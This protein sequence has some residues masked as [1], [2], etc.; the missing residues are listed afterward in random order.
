MSRN[1]ATADL[2]FYVTATGN[3][4]MGDGSLAHPFATAARAY[5]VV[6]RGWD[7][8]GQYNVNVHLSGA[9]ANVRW[10]FLGPLV[11]AIGP[12]SFNIIGV[13]GSPGSTFCQGATGVQ[14]AIVIGSGARICCHDFS[15]NPG[16]GAGLFTVGG[17]ELLVH[18]LWF[19]TNGGAWI[20][21]AAGASSSIT[22]QG[23]HQLWS[24]GGPVNIVAVS[25][26]NAQI[27]LSGAWTMEYSPSWN[28]A[29]VQAD[30][31]GIVDGTGFSAT[32]AGN[33]PR[34]V[35]SVG[36][37]VFTGTGT[38]PPNFFPGSS[39]GSSAGAYYV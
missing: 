26:D 19:A 6:Q 31:G 34:Y 14:E 37:K 18:D 11:G 22:S 29:F 38:A 24:S 9:L 2:D 32:G 10:Q 4:A 12:Q 13:P 25:E 3:D 5:Q 23:G 27:N 20:F 17:G 30:L 16:I 28:T 21:D 15:V 39:P 35:A 36:G 8:M 7:L 33:G 1:Y